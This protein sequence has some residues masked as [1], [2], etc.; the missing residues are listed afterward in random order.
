MLPV[1]TPVRRRGNRRVPHRRYSLPCS[2][3]RVRRNGVLGAEFAA[4]MACQG[5]QRAASRRVVGWGLRMSQARTASPSVRPSTRGT[6]VSSSPAPSVRRNGEDAAGAVDVLDVVVR[7]GGDLAFT[8]TRRERRSMS[9]SWESTPASCAT[10]SR[11]DRVG[12]AA[13]GD[14]RRHGVFERRPW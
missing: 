2:R 13:H 8:G 4:V 5:A 7:V 14:I 9:P 12:Q 10:A 11:W 6:D 3:C 1:S